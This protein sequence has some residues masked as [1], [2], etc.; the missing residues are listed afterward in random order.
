MVQQWWDRTQ[1]SINPQK[2]VIKAFTR[3]RD[4]RGLKKPTLSAHTLQL[5]TEVK[6]LGSE[7]QG[8]ALDLHHGDQNRTDIQSHVWWPRVRNNVSRTEISKLQR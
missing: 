2:M 1:L 3:K 5:T 8:G 7:T 6:H 4:L